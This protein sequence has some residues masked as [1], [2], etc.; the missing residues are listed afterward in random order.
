MR[1]F[2]IFT[3]F[4]FFYQITFSQTT[5]EVNF[6]GS[7]NKNL[8]SIVNSNY[9]IEN[10]L[11]L[12]T[13]IQI[14]KPLLKEWLINFGLGFVP[15]DYIYKGKGNYSVIEQRVS[16]S[17]IQFNLCGYRKIAIGKR[18]V[19]FIGA[20]GFTGYL[21]A[22]KQSGVL[23]N[24]YNVLNLN[25]PSNSVSLSNFSEN[26]VIDEKIDNRFEIGIRISLEIGRAHV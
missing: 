2:L 5:A 14:N 4:F 23:P 7:F 24:I 17:Y 16:N 8:Q 25:T 22:R 12:N 26:Q 13:S 6:G 9:N 10:A 20:G 19:F 15:K 1:L 3:F 18:I 21:I 11:S